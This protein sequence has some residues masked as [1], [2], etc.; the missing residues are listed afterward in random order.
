MR[1]LGW[2]GLFVLIAGCTKPE[3]NNQTEYN[4]GLITEAEIVAS[5]AQTAYDAVKKLRGNYL[6]S[7]GKTTINNTSTEEPTVYLDEQIYGPVNSLKSIPANQVTMIRLY[8][9]WEATTKYGTGNMGGVIA[10]TTR[11]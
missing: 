6:A 11:H 2:L 9:A 10:V 4:S 3:M 7:R 1:R 5:G 8:R